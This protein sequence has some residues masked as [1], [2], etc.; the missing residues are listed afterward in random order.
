MN[1]ATL[2]DYSGFIKI[3]LEEDEAADFIA[4]LR[5]ICHFH[6]QTI[7]NWAVKF[8]LENHK[9]GKGYEWTFSTTGIK[10]LAFALARS[11]NCL[12]AVTKFI[13]AVSQYHVFRFEE[14]G[15][16]PITPEQ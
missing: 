12:S 6:P 4:D 10:T 5:T 14:S 11:E 9:P 7:S 2:D 13:L 3:R 16:F 8:I 1:V 15:R